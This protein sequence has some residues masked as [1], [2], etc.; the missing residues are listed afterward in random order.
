[1]RHMNEIIVKTLLELNNND[2]SYVWQKLPPNLDLSY[3]NF[4]NTNLRGV[5]FRD[6]FI[7]YT[8]FEG[9]RIEDT[10]FDNSW[11]RNSDFLDAHLSNIQFLQTDWFNALHL[12]PDWDGG[13]LM[14]FDTWMSCP[15]S[16]AGD[17]SAWH[18]L[19][20]DWYDATIGADDLG[21]LEAAWNTYRAPNG[22]CDRVLQKKNAH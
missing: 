15:S 9:A 8:S 1:V 10:V 5:H 4:K 18:T 21:Q 12:I 14:Y 20:S 22:L 19:L 16:K 13:T 2:L 3:L 6:A 17:N 11:V 7:I